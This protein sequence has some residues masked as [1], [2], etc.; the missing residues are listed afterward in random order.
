[1]EET[2]GQWEG[3]IIEG[4]VLRKNPRW[5]VWAV[6]LLDNGGFNS[7]WAADKCGLATD[8]DSG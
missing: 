4:V 6:Y 3:T 8:V 7:P 1:M 2:A 5:R